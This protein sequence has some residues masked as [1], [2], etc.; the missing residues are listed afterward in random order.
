MFLINHTPRNKISHSFPLWNLLETLSFNIKKDIDWLMTA[1]FLTLQWNRRLHSTVWRKNSFMLSIVYSS[2]LSKLAYE[3]LTLVAS[4]WYLSGG[5]D[6]YLKNLSFTDHAWIWSY[7]GELFPQYLRSKWHMQHFKWAT[8]LEQHPPLKTHEKFMKKRTV[9]MKKRTVHM[10]KGK[11][12][13]LTCHLANIKSCCLWKHT[14]KFKNI[15]L[16]KEIIISF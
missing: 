8:Y 11:I 2:S 9:H 7:I 12:Y 4:K 5:S 13:H 14:W 16:L 3:V 15:F 1:F 6:F 10:K